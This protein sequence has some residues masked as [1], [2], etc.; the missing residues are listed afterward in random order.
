MPSRKEIIKELKEAKKRYPSDDEFWNHYFN[1]FRGYLPGGWRWDSW[2][3]DDHIEKESLGSDLMNSQTPKQFFD[4]LEKILIKNGFD[5]ERLKEGMDYNR[6][7][8]KRLHKSLIRVYLDL[9]VLGY[10]Y[11]DLCQ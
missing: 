7:Y 3:D 2:R 9:R 4:N 5:L 1:N 10:N 6:L 11:Y 8:G